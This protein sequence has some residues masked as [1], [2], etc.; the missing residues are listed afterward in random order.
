MPFNDLCQSRGIAVPVLICKL[1]SQLK[2]KQ[3]AVKGDSESLQ[4]T[5]KKAHFREV[6]VHL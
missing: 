3:K 4:R 2:L 5:M 1:D 6:Q